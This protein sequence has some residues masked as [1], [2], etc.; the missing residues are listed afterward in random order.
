MRRTRPLF[1]ALL[2][3]FLPEVQAQVE[4]T[5]DGQPTVLEEEIRWL[6]NR[7]RFDSAAENTERGTSYSDIAARRGP[8]APR[9]AIT[10]AARHHSEDL[11]KTDSF[12][13]ETVTGS[14]YY[15]PVTQPNPWD[16]MAAE[17]YSWNAAAENIA[18]G[19]PTA[20]EAYI[21]W[22][23]ST[24]HRTGMYGNYREIGLGYF[25]WEDSSF[26]DYYTMD[27]GNSG[28]AHF[29]TGT[30]YQDIN[31][32]GRYTQGEGTSG[33]RVDLRINGA[34]HTSCDVST[35][36][37]SFAIPMQGL[38]TG[39]VVEI[40]IR[41]NNAAPVTL[42]IPVSYRYSAPVTLQPNE[43]RVWGRFTKASGSV[44]VGFRDLVLEASSL[45]LPAVTIDIDGNNSVVG[46]SSVAGFR[47]QVQWSND[48]AVWQNLGSVQTGTGGT[49]TA[50][51]TG[52]L[53]A[54]A[55]RFYR[56]SV[57]PP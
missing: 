23:N 13:H 57:S 55:K 35:S 24:G 7:G 56:V 22:W 42:H 36:V 5:A 27:L 43:Q 3:A 44:N 25:F 8:V 2:W 31:S 45:P 47:Y 49:L 29:F 46:W 32:N 18:A 26:L 12:Q 11:A 50:T 51:D 19:Y 21:G 52:A 54:S 1:F 17:G 38:A 34:L 40:L 28:S 33:V 16:R 10:L 9:Q 37:G 41:N 30:L 39:S 48:F 20:L 53:V 4:Y 15:N 6:L 14:L